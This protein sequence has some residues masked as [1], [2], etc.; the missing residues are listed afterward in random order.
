MNLID[1]KRPIVVRDDFAAFILT[2]G[3][4]DNV[5]TLR[6]L[7]KSGYTGKVYIIIDNEDK[8]GDEYRKEFGADWVIEFDKKAESE[9]F[10][11]AD[12]QQ[13]RRSIV[14]A[15][16]AS[17]RIAKEMGLD[18]MLQLDDDYTSFCYRFIHNDIIKSTA[19]RNFDGVVDAMIKLLEDTNALTVAFSQGGDHIGGV[20][21]SISKGILRKAMNSFFIRTNRPINF[22]GRINEDVNAYVV[23]GALGDL[24]FTVMNLQLTQVQTQKAKGGLTEIYLDSGTYVKSFYTVM[25]APSCVSVRTMGQTNRRFHHSIKWDNAVPKIISSRHRNLKVIS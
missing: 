18:Y 8:R 7:R 24:F 23:S 13:D 15:R 6:T 17:Q 12:T 14:Y 19:I 1:L 25:M 22:V 10:D 9:L 5:I 2:H 20:D 4:P 11:T 3:R 21:G 16:N